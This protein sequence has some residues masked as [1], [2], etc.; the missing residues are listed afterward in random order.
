MSIDIQ[1]EAER[2]AALVAEGKEAEAA[3]Y[4]AAHQ[5][6]WTADELWGVYDTI[7]RVQTG[8]MVSPSLIFTEG[9][10]AQQRIDALWKAKS[11][12]G[13]TAGYIQ[14]ALRSG[15]P[16]SGDLDG[17]GTVDPSEQKAIDAAKAAYSKD[18]QDGTNVSKAEADKMA[19][20]AAQSTG[21]QN[22]LWPDWLRG[23]AGGSITPEQMT[24]LLEHWNEL[25]PN[26]Q[27]ADATQLMQRMAAQTL[28]ANIVAQD[29]LLG[30]DPDF[31]YVV[32]LADG[33]TTTVQRSQFETLQAMTGGDFDAAEVNRLVRLADEVGMSHVV[34][35][36]PDGQP[37]KAVDYAPAVLLANALGV[38]NLAIDKTPR[39][40]AVGRDQQGPDAG[41]PTSRQ[42]QYVSDI[43]KL[44]NAMV[45]YQY[46]SAIYN[47]NVGLAYL[48]VM[49][50]ALA[51]RVASTPWD[52]LSLQDRQQANR[53]FVQGGVVKGDTSTE[54]G[55]AGV[56]GGDQLIDTGTVQNGGRSRS[57]G[58]GGGGYSR[59]M[60]D[61][62]AVKQAARD[63]FK[64]LFMAEPDEAQ[65]QQF[66]QIVQSQISSAPG[67]QSVDASARLRDILENNA[68]YKEFY[69]K[70]GG[71]SDSEYQSQFR[72]AGQE[73]LGAEA[74]DPAAIQ[75]GMR[76]GNYQTTIGQVA[77]SKKAWNNSTFLG[78]LAQA[79]QVI[80]ENT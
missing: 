53:L 61:P 77:G 33:S 48:G 41:L 65:L 45:A 34:G 16:W 37:Q 28:D 74:A 35:T 19:E 76:T 44:R 7:S 26:D 43:Y 14:N 73:M 38:T 29:V 15:T 12:E 64:S 9:S 40:N 5:A 24:S 59:T 10:A 60:P 54:W 70:S 23:M 58:G 22:V 4:V 3:A 63:M 68:L 20:D 11:G 52:Q 39:K 27:V 6:S 55:A 72:S 31:N 80:N 42:E 50:S 67:N 47:G 1:A 46:N 62:V 78:R 57:G 56:T 21:S 2:L 79:A 51:S 49:D 25:H 30:T 71:L 17:N 69:G 18:I 75:G 13:G 36:G 66:V 32:R 8:D